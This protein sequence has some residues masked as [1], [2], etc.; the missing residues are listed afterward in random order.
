VARLIVQSL[1][2]DADR[3]V[4][5]SALAACGE[6]DWPYFYYSADGH[7][8]TPLIADRW[9]R[10]GVLDRIPIDARDRLLRA[11][12]DNAARN[13]NVCREVIEYW[14][15]IA[16][17]G[18][19]AIVLKGWPLVE[20]LYE[21]PALR[22]IA[23]TDLLVPADRAWDGLAALER[24]GLE[25][26][27]LDRDAWVEKHLPA[28]WRLNGRKVTYPL[29]NLF[30][31]LHPRSVE[32]H[33]KVW[34]QNF[35]GLSLRDPAGFW[36]RSRVVEVAGRPMRIPSLEDMFIHLCVHWACHWIERGARLAQLV[37]L[38]RFVR[39]YGDHVDWSLIVQVGAAAGVNRFVCAALDVAGCLLGTP[40]PPAEV[41]RQLRAGCPPGL[42]RWINRYAADDMAL[43]D[44]RRPDKGVA[45]VLTWLSTQSLGEKLGVARY[46]LLP[47]AKF[48][49]GRYHLRRRWLAIPFY[50]PYVIGRLIGVIKP[51]VRALVRSA[52]LE[53]AA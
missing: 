22:P 15:L 12:H 7:G 17:A 6:V 30:D 35:R 48:I 11:Y 29:A 3:S 5:E 2:V 1:R 34:E 42:R 41:T 50:I 32:L 53:S 49:M 19:P 44:Y 14:Q 21:S 4:V 24:A 51:F 20:A 18:I 33:V 8:V 13:E 27:P 26:L 45:Y 38:D 36:D 40:Q 10:L 23:D 52:R 28:Y 37:D 16:D 9:R 46:A 25:P 43:L 39:K 31:P 47:P